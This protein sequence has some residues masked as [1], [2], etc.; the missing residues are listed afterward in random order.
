MASL[1]T[2]YLEG[3]NPLKASGTIRISTSFS[4]PAVA[5][6]VCFLL[7]S[8]YNLSSLYF[9]YYFFY[10]AVNKLHVHGPVP[11]EYLTCPKNLASVQK[12]GIGTNQFT[13]SFPQLLTT[14]PGSR[15]LS[16]GNNNVTGV[17]PSGLGKLRK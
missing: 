5:S 3:N 13:G 2:N 15:L 16:T 8:L 7:D 4:C 1:A 10:A 17:V 14:P 9:F 12:F 11:S 6:P